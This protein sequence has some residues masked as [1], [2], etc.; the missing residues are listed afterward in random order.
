M[1]LSERQEGFT[2][3]EV[4]VALAVIAL[5]MAGVMKVA[6]SSVATATQIEQSTIAHWVAMNQ[7]SYH[8]ARMEFSKRS[9]KGKTLMAGHEWIWE[10]THKE[11][12]IKFGK[13][14]IDKL[15]VITINV[16]YDADDEAPRASLV[17]AFP[18]DKQAQ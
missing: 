18:T 8:Q 11:E 6:G 12:E 4:L 9:E 14:V 7:L 3:F 15:N 16:Y 5:S 10:T 2:L 17:T 13:Q 1:I